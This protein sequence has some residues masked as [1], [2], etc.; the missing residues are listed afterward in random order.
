MTKKNPYDAIRGR[1]RDGE[2]W[3]KDSMWKGKEATFCLVGA[4]NWACAV[5]RRGFD[6]AN[7]IRDILAEVVQEQYPDRL[8]QATYSTPTGKIVDFNDD[9]RT[10]W[11]DIDRVLDKAR[12]RW[13][14]ESVHD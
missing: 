4:A 13:E 10:D 6:E 2:G 14:E 8:D 5:Q 7:H 1:L 12:A 3:H 11:P 9:M